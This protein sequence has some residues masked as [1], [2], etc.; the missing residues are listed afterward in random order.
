MNE[1]SYN[2]YLRMVKLACR[3]VKTAV[4]RE[5]GITDTNMIQVKIRDRDGL[6]EMVSAIVRTPESAETVYA[7]RVS[8]RIV[9]S[10]DVTLLH[11]VNTA[12][13]FIQSILKSRTAR[14]CQKQIVNYLMAERY[15]DAAWDYDKQ[16]PVEDGS[17]PNVEYAKSVI[18]DRY[19][20]NFIG[21]FLLDDRPRI[22]PSILQG[23]KAQA[24]DPDYSLTTEEQNAK[25]VDRRYARDFGMRTDVFLTATPAS[26]KVDTVK[27]TEQKSMIDVFIKKQK[28]S[29]TEIIAQLYQT[30]F[31]NIPLQKR[32][33]RFVNLRSKN[34]D[35]EICPESALKI[36][37][38]FSQIEATT[39]HAYIMDYFND[40]M[41]PGSTRDTYYFDQEAWMYKYMWQVEGLIY[42]QAGSI[43]LPDGSAIEVPDSMLPHEFFHRINTVYAAL[44]GFTPEDAV[45]GSNWLIDSIR[46]A[47][48]DEGNALYCLT[49]IDK[50]LENIRTEREEQSKW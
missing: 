9:I 13:V 49:V 37:R 12:A 38:Q 35:V 20:L 11:Q 30:S 22:E 4:C 48:T 6:V 3:N 29:E 25:L 19:S 8:K 42:E 23:L 32:R 18:V 45:G 26:F 5:N 28:T 27:D 33:R 31:A 1:K 10:T 34:R 46:S 43:Y 14:I 40:N 7:S 50:R 17:M 36:K 41:Q 15:L 24:F 39:K 21:G 2:M 47:Y 44:F 16:N